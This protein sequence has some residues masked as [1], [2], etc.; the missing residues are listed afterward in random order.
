M[1]ISYI[2]IIGTL[3]RFFMDTT[4]CHYNILMGK[5]IDYFYANFSIFHV[6]AIYMYFCFVHFIIET[7]FMDIITFFCVCVCIFPFLP[8]NSL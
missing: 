4:N 3:L 2:D 7:Y 6:Y 8:K 1:E 5:L